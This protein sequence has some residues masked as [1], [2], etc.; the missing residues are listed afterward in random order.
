MNASQLT[1]LDALVIAAHPDDA[2]IS[3]G[4]TILRL[5]DAGARVGDLDITRGEMGTRGSKEDRDAE[6]ARATEVMG[7]A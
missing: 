2:E 3:A 4:G 5:I 6:T 1:K 7:L